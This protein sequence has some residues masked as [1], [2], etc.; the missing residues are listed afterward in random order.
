MGRSQDT[1]LRERH[2]KL[3]SA[4]NMLSQVSI[5]TNTQDKKLATVV[6]SKYWGFRE[7]AINLLA[8]EC[9]L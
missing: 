4:H 1:L 6:A 9:P 3:N 8:L 2:R 7:N 5:F